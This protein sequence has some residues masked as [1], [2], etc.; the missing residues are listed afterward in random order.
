MRFVAIALI[1]IGILTAGVLVSI[2]VENNATPFY[3]SM[4]LA[5]IAI[6]VG[7]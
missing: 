6:V 1:I 4:L 2:F 7:E 3:W 5:A